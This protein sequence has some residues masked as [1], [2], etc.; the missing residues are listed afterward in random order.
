MSMFFSLLVFYAKQMLKSFLYLGTMLFMVIMLI[1]RFVIRQNHLHGMTD[2]GN[3]VGEMT[4]IV[5]AVM[6]LFM[7]FFYKLFSDEYKFGANNLFI[8]SFRITLLK[9]AALLCIHLLFL[10]VF[11]GIQTALIFIFYRVWEIPF[12]SFYTQTVSYV[13]VY[14]YLPFVFSFFLGIFTALLFGKN[15]LSFVF[16]III[17]LAIGPMN[18]T[19]F[20][21]YFRQFSFSDI[22]SLFYIGPLNINVVFEDVIGYNL[23]FSTYMK[24]FF[25]IMAAMIA[26]FAALFKTTRTGQEK[27][28]IIVVIVFLLIGNTLIFPKIFG[29]GKLVFSFAD[30]NQ[31]SLYYK[32]RKDAIDPSTLQYTIQR[33][34]IQLDARNHVKAETKVTLDQI[35][36]QTLSFVL[37][38]FFDVKK[39]TNKEGRRL[40]FTQQGDFV[41]VERTS[42]Q[43]SDELTFYYEMNDSAHLPVSPSYLFLPNYFSWVPTKANHTPFDFNRV[44][45]EGTIVL[46]M[47]TKEPIHYTLSFKGN[48]PFYTNLPRNKDGTYSGEVSGGITAVAGMFTKKQFGD[49]E[50][51]YPNDWSDITEDWPIFQ[52]YLVQVHKEIVDMFQ[53]KDMKL[54]N[55]MILLAPNSE[56]NSYLS[57]DHLLFQI[58]TLYSISS[59]YTLDYIPEVFLQALLWNYDKRTFSSYEQI[60]EFNKLLANIV[61]D[62][63]GL[64]SP[65]MFFLDS[66]LPWAFEQYDQ[67]TQNAVRRLYEEYYRLPNEKKKKFLVLW[68]KEMHHVSDSWLKTAKL[69]QE[70]REGRQ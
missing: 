44:Y 7:V 46:S 19:L 38:H 41:V 59:R 14:W 33:Y 12:S 4:L 58:G 57:S 11:I 52:K 53:I 39:V 32:N 34:D 18:T 62:E 36:S 70:F 56:M 27:I 15:K 23:S 54:P 69:F 20:S 55:K 67:E 9:I 3:F 61:Q 37:Y 64:Q 13:I 16:M 17:W 1:S 45:N 50:V 43:P 42:N 24:I 65:G 21:R 6:L 66:N 31:E 25:W 48:V 35:Q 10:A 26:I 30:L 47:Q 5:Q 51:V 68:Y 63:L 28:A 49:W 22:E 2:Y 60:K 40:P 29:G 8:G